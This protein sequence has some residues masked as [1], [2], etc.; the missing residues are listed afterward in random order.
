MSPTKD[1]QVEVLVEISNALS[2]SLDMERNLESILNILTGLLEMQRGTITLV[3]P[4]TNELHI[5]VAQG[6]TKE[7]KERGRY[8]IGEGITGKVVETGQPMVVKDIGAEPLFLNRTRSRQDLEKRKFA[9]LCVPIKVGNKVIGA[10]SVDHLFRGDVSYEEDIKL[11]TIIAS[12]VGQAV[13]VRDLAE[14][15]KQAVVS[16]NLKLKRELQGKYKFGNIIYGSKPMAAVA[17]GALQVADSQA[18]ILITGESGTGKELLA[19]AIHYASG[20]ANNAFIK[21]ACAALPENLLESELFGY[22]RGAFTGAVERKVGRFELADGGTIFLDE[23][24][25]LTLA[26]QV[27]LL[28]V[29]Q[30]REFERLGGTKSLKVDVRVICATHRDLKQ[31]V[32]DGKFR[33]DLF[34]RIN[35]FPIDLPPLRDRKEDIPLLADHFMHKYVKENRKKIKG[36]S[37]AA[38]DLLI[39][40]HWPGNV[41]E[42]EN[43]MERAVVLCQKDVITPKELP[44]GLSSKADLSLPA[45]GVTLPEMVES[46][47]KQKIIE[48]LEKFKTQRN[49]AK[50]LGL[51]ERMLGYKIKKY[52]IQY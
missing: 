46:I 52:G 34:Y 9:F 45:T 17:E 5:E 27:K 36:I 6:L 19:S 38:L 14:A 31:M 18:T 23:I 4:E 24:G 43:V 1:V 51:T 28:R 11:L 40:Y 20:R 41:R 33:E 13:R 7:E 50:A 32:K 42:L 35:V 10:L 47:E 49:A 25:D 48:G 12:I 22:E 3:D 16:E 2:S 44:P 30:E 37:R 29:L 26:T 39:A 21:V 8:Q 15:D